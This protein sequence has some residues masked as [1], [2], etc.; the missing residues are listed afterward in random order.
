MVESNALSIN[1]AFY[2]NLH[3]SGHIM[4]AFC[5]DPESEYNEGTAVMGSTTTAVRDPFFFRWHSFIDDLFLR[6]KET[7]PPYSN[8]ELKYDN[9]HITEI[10][11]ISTETDAT[12]TELK[13]FWQKTDVNIS[14]GLDFQ[15]SG[16]TY[17]RFTHLNYEPF[18]YR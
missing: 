9:V 11:F 18:S 4:T 17:V 5:H 12:T 3:G 15:A 14:N 10:E 8:D 16:P 6:H 13:T 1:G 2:G 7:L